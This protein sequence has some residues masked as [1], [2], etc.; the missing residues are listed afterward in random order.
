MPSNHL[1]LSSPSHET[2]SQDKSSQLETDQSISQVLKL[3]DKEQKIIMINI[4]KY[5][6]EK[7]VKTF[8]EKCEGIHSDTETQPNE[9]P[10][11]KNEH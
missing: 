6:Q 2:H 3:E 11:T 5:L 9:T 4:L 8:Q 7:M 10:R 1:I